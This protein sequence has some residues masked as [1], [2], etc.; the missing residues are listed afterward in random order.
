M[1]ACHLIC[2]KQLSESNAGILLIELRGTNFREILIEIY[3]SSFKKMHLKMSS[4]KWCTFFLGLNYTWACF[5]SLAQSKLRL[6]SA[7]HRPGYWSNL[8]CDW[9]STAWAYSEQETPFKSLSAYLSATPIIKHWSV[10]PTPNNSLAKT[11]VTS[12]RINL[13]TVC[14]RWHVIPSHDGIGIHRL[15]E[16]MDVIW[17][18]PFQ[19]CDNSHW[20]K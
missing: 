13:I 6:C 15:S 14:I 18:N 20:L 10:N 1:M 9:L 3:T 12:Q 8:P 11:A 2:A 5:L 4:A 16:N 19:F 7:N 17:I